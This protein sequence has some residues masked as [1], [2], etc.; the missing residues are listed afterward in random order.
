VWW[1]SFALTLFTDLEHTDADA[2]RAK[3]GD[4]DR[5]PLG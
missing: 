4:L 5:V 3:L 2:V 1:W